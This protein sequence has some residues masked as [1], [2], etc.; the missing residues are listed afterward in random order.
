MLVMVLN[1]LDEARLGDLT[2][3]DKVLDTVLVG[4]DDVAGVGPVGEQAA[5][6]YAAGA[7][8]EHDDGGSAEE[9]V[10]LTLHLADAGR[11]VDELFGLHHAAARGHSRD[12]QA[13]FG[14][15]DDAGGCGHGLTPFAKDCCHNGM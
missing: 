14:F 11:S 7:V 5:L 13:F 4:V 1:G 3:F 15:G 12:W 8:A 10:R 2:P 6:A 9:P